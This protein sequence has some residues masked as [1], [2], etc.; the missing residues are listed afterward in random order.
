[1]FCRHVFGNI[2][3]DFAVFCFLGGISRDFAGPRPRKISEALS[4]IYKALSRK[5]E[6]ISIIMQNSDVLDHS[7]QPSFMYRPPTCTCDVILS[8]CGGKTTGS[9]SSNMSIGEHQHCCV[10]FEICMNLERTIMC[11]LGGIWR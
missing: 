4:T 5:T 2:L 10:T 9:P 6:K 3:A 7:E 1:M 8:I 11:Y